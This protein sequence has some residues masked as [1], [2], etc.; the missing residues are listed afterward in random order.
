MPSIRV[1]RQKVNDDVKKWDQA[2]QDA[3]ELLTKVEGRAARLRGAIKTF[4]ELRDHGHR[5]SGPTSAREI[6]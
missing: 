5:F 6:Q 1:S 2:I 4:T 3:Q